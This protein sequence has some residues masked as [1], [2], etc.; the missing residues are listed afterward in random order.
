MSLIG[1]L[2]YNNQII[3]EKWGESKEHGQMVVER[4]AKLRSITEL[5]DEVKALP[6]EKL[7]DDA[8]QFLQDMDLSKK[9]N[10]GPTAEAKEF[11]HRF[12]DQDAPVSGWNTN[13]GDGDDPFF[14]RSRAIWAR[15]EEVGVD[16]F[17][18]EYLKEPKWSLSAWNVDTA[19]PY[20]VKEEDVRRQVEEGISSDKAGLVADDGKKTLASTIADIGLQAYVEEQLAMKRMMDYLQTH[21]KDLGNLESFMERVIDKIEENQPESLAGIQDII[22]QEIEGLPPKEAQRVLD[23]MERATAYALK[24]EP[25]AEQLAEEEETLVS[26]GSVA[27]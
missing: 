10:I 14:R 22:R 17:Q 2:G 13:N 25:E 9:F 4:S 3:H 23:F 16:A 24:L 18:Q 20:A 12:D 5:H 6:D 21:K 11:F 8:R 27:A 1:A 19:G 15:I 7:T 26:D